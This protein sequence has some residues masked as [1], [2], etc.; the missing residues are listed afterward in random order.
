MPRLS[1]RRRST[2]HV[3]IQRIVIGIGWR[4]HNGSRGPSHTNSSILLQHCQD[5]LFQVGF[6]ILPRSH[7]PGMLLKE[8]RMRKESPSPP[9]KHNKQNLPPIKQSSRAD[10]R[11]P[12]SNTRFNR[13]EWSSEKKKERRAS[14]EERV[15][16]HRNP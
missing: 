9:H 3:L 7:N 16:C 4:I 15:P 2:F 8:P 1:C 13:N 14:H 12:A 10:Q 11:Q 5:P 6:L